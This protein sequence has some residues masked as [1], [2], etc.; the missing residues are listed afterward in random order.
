MIYPQALTLCSLFLTHALWAATPTNVQFTS[1]SSE[2]ISASWSLD[3]PSTEQPLAVLSEASDFST[4]VS[5]GTGSIGQET[6]TY[7]NLTPNTTHYFKVKVSTEPDTNYSASISTL[8]LAAPPTGSYVLSVTSFSVRFT[9]SLNENPSGTEFEASISTSQDFIP[10]DLGGWAANATSVT[11][12]GLDSFT[13]YYM[14]VQARNSAKIVTA[15]DT[16]VS[17]RTD[18]RPIEF[19]F[20]WGSADLYGGAE[21]AWGDYDNDGDPDIAA[22]FGGNGDYT[23]RVYR[24]DGNGSFTLVW[25]STHTEDTQSAAWGDYDNDGDLDLAFGNE[26]GLTE[27]NVRL[28]RND[29]ADTFT[30]V[31]A[32]TETD[33]NREL[34]WGDFDNDG[35][36]D[37]VAA[38]G[39]FQS[40]LTR[41]YENKGDGSFVNA[42]SKA[43]ADNDSSA[44]WGDYDNDGNLDIL[45]GSPVQFT[46][47]YQGD[48]TGAFT[49]I[50]TS[51]ETDVGE[52]VRWVDIDQDGLLDFLGNDG[53]TGY[54]LRYYR[55]TGSTF[56]LTTSRSM[57]LDRHMS[58]ADFDGDGD[59]DL[60]TKQSGSGSSGGMEV[61]IHGPP[62]VFTEIWS[63]T[64]GFGGGATVHSADMDGDGKPDLLVS[65][66]CVSGE[67]DIKVYRNVSNGSNTAPNPPTSGFSSSYNGQTETLS[68]RWDPGSD[69]ESS[70]NTLVY[71]LRVGTQPAGSNIVSG[72]ASPLLGNYVHPFRVSQTQLGIALKNIAS[73]ATYYWSLK[74]R[75]GAGLLSSAWSTEQSIFAP[76]PPF[77]IFNLTGSALGTSSITWSWDDVTGE[78]G[79]RILDPS[80]VNLSGDLPANTTFW[81]ETSLSTN[82]SYS[83][84]LAAFNSGG[85]S[86]STAVTRYTQAAPPTGTS[87]VWVTTTSIRAG[88]NVNTNPSGTEFE[89]V[90]STTADFLPQTPGGW[91]VD[92]TSVT[93][94]GLSAN[95][96]YHLRVHARNGDLVETAYDV[97]V[98]TSTNANQPAN[99]MVNSVSP[100]SVSL[101]WDPQGNRTGTEYEVQRSTDGSS[102]A[103]VALPTSTSLTDTGLIP[104]TTYWY[105][106]RTKS[107]LGVLTGFDT[108][109]STHT[110]PP[111]ID[112]SF[113]WGLDTTDNPGGVAW[114]DYDNDGDLD[115]GVAYRGQSNRIYRNDGNGVFTLVWSS[116]HSEQ[117]RGVAWGDYDRDG[118]LD[119]AFGNDRAGTPDEPNV[120][121]YRNNGG[122]AFTL[123]WTSAEMDDNWMLAWG[124]SDNDGDWDLLAANN[125]F[126]SPSRLR[127]YRNDGS[128]F[129]SV[130]SATEEHFVHSAVWGDYNND[131]QLDILASAPG[132]PGQYT[133]IYRNDGSNTF[134]L[135]WSSTETGIAD[136]LRWVDLDADGNLD[137]LTLDGDVAYELRYYK[138]DGSTFTLTA[139]N[140]VSLDDYIAIADLDADGDIDVA[141]ARNGS[142]SSEGN[143]AF[144]ND[145]NGIFVKVWSSTHPFGSA[146]VALGDMDGDGRADLLSA[147]YVDDP[148]VRVYRNI[149]ASTFT[150]PTAPSSGFSSIY[151][152]STQVLSLRW[153]PGS[154][155]ESSSNTLVYVLRVGTTSAGNSV[156]SGAVA[157]LLGS[158]LHPHRVSQTQLG[159][160]IQNVSPAPGATYYWSVKVIDGGAH[161]GSAWSTGQNIYVPGPPAVPNSFGGTA[162]STGSIRWSWLNTTE[163]DGYRVFRGTSQISSDLAANTTFW[164]ETGLSTNTSNAAQVVAFN[165]VGN[166]TSTAVSVYT[167]ATAPTGTS[168]TSASS[169]TVSLSWSANTNP[170]GTPYEVSRSTDDFSTSFSTPVPLASNHTGTAYTDSSLTPETTYYYRIRAFNGDAIPSSF[171]TVQSTRTRSP[172]L[173]APSGFSGTALSTS[174]L[175]WSW[176][177]I[178]GEN[179]YRVLRATDNAN[180]SGDLASDSTFWIQTG[181]TANT[182]QQVYVEAFN[183][184]ETASTSALTRYTLARKSIN[185]DFSSVW[186]TSATLTW[187]LNGNP[188]YTDLVL[189]RSTDGAAFSLVASGPYNSLHPYTDTGLSDQTTYYFRIKARN[190]D[191]VET[192]YDTTISTQTLAYPLPI[193]T[194]ISTNTADNLSKIF[195]TVGGKNFRSGASLKLTKSAQA[196]RQAPSVSFASSAT[197]TANLDF[198]GA[199]SGT[200]N[201]IVTN[202]DGQDSGTSGND[203]FTVTL[204]S[205]TTEVAVATVSS[206]ANVIII[207]AGNTTVVDIPAGA[208]EDGTVFVSVDPTNKPIVV[209]PADIQSANQNLPANLD[210]VSGAVREF[211]AFE[212]SGVQ[213]TSY[214]SIDVTI[215]IAYPDDNQDGFIDGTSVPEGVL[216]CMTLN[217][218]IQRWEEVPGAVVDSIQNR[219]RVSVQHFSV[220]ALFMPAAAANLSKARAY[221]NPWKPASGGKQDASGITF[222]RLT[223]NA[224]VKVFTIVGELVK[225]IQ[226]GPGDGGTKVWNGN[227]KAGRNVG[228]G[229]YL[230]HIKSSSGETRVLKIAIER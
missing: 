162:L 156:V 212:S 92:A 7:F 206:S 16:A 214:F 143:Q 103:S 102:Y 208:M 86:T 47:I 90:V 55:N 118:D 179:G 23:N 52:S 189:E 48:G 182:S 61:Y 166:S 107:Q 79:Y 51:T 44:V 207:T 29:G 183:L 198:V 4:V 220:Y 106:V 127:V 77:G 151:S 104:S 105:R 128:N 99:T 6:T 71:V 28:Y 119:I 46:R 199:S 176:Q 138:N 43:E 196:D 169:T 215:E 152:T 3:N 10:A 94:S 45:T 205:S 39:T 132:S 63:S 110:S 116:T 115:I 228:S 160:D 91:S 35:D 32:S 95:T 229:V 31:W 184:D 193:V 131:G 84:R 11:I 125:A 49:L 164:I 69:A 12:S 83:R 67:P 120:R 18:P 88:W 135:V 2:S 85:T 123:V 38:N 14:R 194:S 75:D 216:K 76:A 17:T 213:K 81:T 5:S 74:V 181:L 78:D 137:F 186:I 82:T 133:R 108:A 20:Q 56:T 58:L 167:L 145:G 187:D 13:T 178:S 170:S 117:T 114:G 177:D 140:S 42:W 223:D 157:P 218:F 65:D 217:E 70:S 62:G 130:W 34:N 148:R 225:E 174:S 224:T 149:T 96:T 204:A 147:T 221:P 113:Y 97:L 165:T 191:G 26:D 168:I 230:A 59:L 87:I 136:T 53:N 226:L 197:L 111:E 180:L 144:R 154:D 192:S 195:V 134:T 185:S 171:D 161:V 15:Y 60:A 41:V 172:P 201:V 66:C 173:S 219:V 153:G 175:Q 33:L 73:G 64:H 159:I 211:V 222:D 139:V 155:A 54:E 30:P 8:T 126:F 101:S 141:T 40:G 21:A 163:E 36:L 209:N 98:A 112:F 50:W 9:W 57:S 1:V 227:N 89:A 109:L 19:Y 37:L 188:S 150:A 129:V 146:D 190:G 100:T 203:L 27:P 158:Y 25:T 122:G 72:A 202:P 210:A 22:A 200:W 121:L 24:N 142:G 68:L 124:D 80:D 93:I